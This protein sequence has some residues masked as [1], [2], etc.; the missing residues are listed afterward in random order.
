MFE[1]MNFLSNFRALFKLH[2]KLFVSR[3]LAKL[4]ADRMGRPLDALSRQAGPI[5]ASCPRDDSNKQKRDR[6]DRQ[7]ESAR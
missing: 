4:L 7:F 1:G 5:Y 6:L 2:A 3:E